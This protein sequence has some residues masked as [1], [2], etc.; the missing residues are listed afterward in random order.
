MSETSLAEVRVIM[1]GDE[2]GEVG[3]TEQD[4]K[5]LHV[6]E[7]N[8][9]NLA[10]LLKD[11]RL[12]LERRM[13]RLESERAY[14]TDLDRVERD[15]WKSLEEKADRKELA[16]SALMHLQEQTER[17]AGQIAGLDKRLVWVYAFAAGAGFVGSV[18]GF[19]VGELIHLWK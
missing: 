5:S 8:Q 14:K 9:N 19:I 7:A 15:I 16:S 6:L 17:Q 3:F 2:F 12:S 1:A 11:F 4:R 13:D 10:D 18:V